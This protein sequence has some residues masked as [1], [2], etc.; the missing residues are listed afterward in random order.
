MLHKLWQGFQLFF[1]L[2]FVGTLV[3]SKV[4]PGNPRLAWIRNFRLADNRTEEQKRSAR[5]SRTV[6]DGIEM[7]LMGLAL[8]PLYLFSTVL[9]FFSGVNPVVLAG[10]ILFSLVLI[11]IGIRA[12]IKRA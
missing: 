12:I 6:M 7:I 11:I 8:P 9:F 1:V 3:L 4:T 5:R 10:T 2:V